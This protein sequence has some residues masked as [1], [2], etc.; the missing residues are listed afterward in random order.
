MTWVSIDSDV[1]LSPHHYLNIC[2]LFVNWTLRNKLQWNLNQNTKLFIQENAFV[3]VV[4]E[5]AVSFFS[6]GTELINAP[7][8]ARTTSPSVSRKRPYIFFAENVPLITMHWAPWHQALSLW[9]I[10]YHLQFSRIFTTGSA[11]ISLRKSM[12]P[13][14]TL[15]VSK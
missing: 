2:W 5:L 14:M 15:S 6:W 10:Y 9:I 1:G 4:C 8:F 3:N 12:Y 13:M 7:N 11:N